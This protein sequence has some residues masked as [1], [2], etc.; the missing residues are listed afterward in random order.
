VQRLVAVFLVSVVVSC[1]Q[2]DR[3][4][5]R[6]VTG[7]ETDTFTQ[8][9]APTTLRVDAVRGLADGGV[10]ITTLGTASLPTTALDLGSENESTAAELTVAGF[11]DSGD[12]VLQGTSLVLDFSSLAGTTI[13]VFVQR[14]GQFARLPGPLADS[15]QTPTLAIVSGRY[16]FVG[17]G[18]DPSIATTTQLYDFMQLAAVG[19]APLLPRV[20]ESIAFDGTVGWLMD[21]DGGNYFDFSDGSREDIELPAGGGSFADVAGG[22]TVVDENGAQYVVGATRTTGGASSWILKID[23][24]DTTN[25][26]YPFGNPTWLELL[27]PR[28]G[29]AAT[30]VV[31][32]GLVVAGG[33]AT[34]AGAE[35]FFEGS[36]SPVSRDL[37]YAPDGSI[38]SGAAALDAQRVLLAGGAVSGVDAGV[39]IIDIGCTPPL[40]VGVCVPTT[41]PGLPT[42]ITSAQV[43]SSNS[44]KVM[45]VGS[46]P[47][48]AGD[49]GSTADAGVTHV[50]GLTSSG[51][52]AIAT[53]V[54][55]TNARAIASPLGTLVLYGGAGEI[56]SFTGADLP[57]KL[58]L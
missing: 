52:S 14:T 43:F 29:A 44:G 4:T 11:D 25:T 54:P 7:G 18:T 6:L 48:S 33:S 3:A 45:V 27:A 58:A 5:I 36:S 41:W 8:A 21:A 39:R 49:G 16:L 42:V 24:N 15:R 55:H 1:S 53:K 37:P 56:E 50:Y 12:Q 20:P 47:P 57:P 31:G 9:P 22:A 19:S 2:Q 40:G 34:A 23:P 10:Q 26:S 38:G 17:G 28:A 46:E 51:P 13:P 30:W 35:I 32:Q